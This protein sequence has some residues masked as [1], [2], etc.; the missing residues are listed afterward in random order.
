MATP[1]GATT[2]SE[3]SATASDSH[4]AR[5]GER[6]CCAEPGAEQ[7][8]DQRPRQRGARARRALRHR[9]AHRA[10][11]DKRRRR[12]RRRERRRRQ[13]DRRSSGAVQVPLCACAV[14]AGEEGRRRRQRGAEMLRSR[15]GSG[16]KRGHV[17]KRRREQDHD[18]H[19]WWV[20]RPRSRAEQLLMLE[21]WLLYN[22]DNKKRQTCQ[23]SGINHASVHGLSGAGARRRG[24][25]RR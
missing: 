17:S 12:E 9:R 21:R 11:A 3:R 24:R 25:R 5:R 13:G 6:V 2:L 22:G 10:R 19:G 15:P 7:E 1:R 23:P 8:G 18:F 20:P 14:R 4:T 16:R